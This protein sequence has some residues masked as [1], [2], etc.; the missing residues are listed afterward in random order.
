MY[1]VALPP[2]GLEVVTTALN[3]RGVLASQAIFFLEA[4]VF[5]RPAATTGC[6]NGRA[7]AYEAGG[8]GGTTCLITFD[9]LPE[10]PFHDAVEVATATAE[11][12]RG[13]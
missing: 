1:L 3:D 5:E 10:A 11:A 4:K 2:C 13:T 12:D 6:V 7:A 8:G 9:L